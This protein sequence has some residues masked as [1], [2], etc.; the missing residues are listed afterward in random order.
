MTSTMDA[1]PELRYIVMELVKGS[2]LRRLL[3][4]SGRLSAERAVALMREICSA[5]AWPTDRDCCIEI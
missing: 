4:D 5:S 3:R 2:S 1:W